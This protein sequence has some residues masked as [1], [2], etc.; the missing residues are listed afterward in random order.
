[1]FFFVEVPPNHHILSVHI[2]LTIC[3]F[4]YLKHY[5]VLKKMFFAYIYNPLFSF[6]TNT[7]DFK[8]R[9]NFLCVKKLSPVSSDIY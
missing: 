1:M 9:G 8:N 4:K 6:V 2:V 3:R 5:I 7:L